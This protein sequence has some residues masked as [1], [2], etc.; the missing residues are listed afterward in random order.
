MREN[1]KQAL[2][3]AGRGLRVFPLLPDMKRP[4]FAGWQA[5]A[6]SDPSAIRTWYEGA[7]ADSGVG[8]ATGQGVFVVDADGA[9]GKASL[10]VLEMSGAD[11]GLVVDTPSGGR[12]AYFTA[13]DGQWVPNSVKS[14]SGYPGID[15]RGDGGFVAAPGSSY[16]GKPY[17]LAT[18]GPLPLAPDWLVAAAVGGRKQRDKAD[19]NPLV[20]LDT[21]PAI[22]RAIEY[23]RDKAPGAVAFAFGNDTTYKVAA[24]VKDF[25]IS[26]E[27]TTTLLA[28]HWNE[29]K[30]E[31]PWDI[32]E[33]MAIVA[34]A[35]A[36]GTSSPGAMSALAEF[37]AV[38]IDEPANDNHSQLKRGL[39]L[40]DFPDAVGKA[41][42][43]PAPHLVDGILEQN[44][45][46]V[47]Y[48]P[49]N[50][51]KTFLC[52]ALAY[53]I[54]AG[55]PWDGHEVDPGAVVYVAAEGG[56]GVNKRL[57]ALNTHFAPSSP[58]P[59]A[60]VPCPIDLNKSD[61]DVKA[62]IRLAKGYAASKAQP[63]R[64]IVIDTLSR[65]LAGGDENSSVDMGNFI[66][67][68]DRLRSAADCTV[69]VVHHT[70]KNVANGA[71]G[72]SGLRAAIDTEIEVEEGNLIS[73][74]KQRD[75]DKIQPKNFK[76]EIVTIGTTPNG[77]DITSCVLQIITSAEA[78]FNGRMDVP[79]AAQEYLDILEG[80]AEGGNAVSAK[81]WDAE[82]ATYLTE[83][84]RPLV[85]DRTLKR[86]R[87]TLLE[88]SRVAKV[89]RTDFI[90][91]DA[92]GAAGP[93]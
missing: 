81:D 89:G 5:A 29:T 54:A 88:S 53:H 49:S 11:I 48:G 39:Y 28:E 46:A 35:Y 71:R 21:E 1:I 13:P 91:L 60:L 79:P 82:F 16:N 2:H 47:V 8:V 90:M 66:K 26:E 17:T 7:Y 75:L 38:S 44:T 86:Y 40:V 58:P 10:D 37:D 69:L 19:S 77:K 56:R 61:A 41:L 20:E 62:I 12:H 30:A 24:K 22:A 33:I 43:D 14:L 80:L 73:V 15:I 3:L 42:A 63:L 93:S 18:D 85:Q 23:L 55:L 72:W 27:M 34:N 6:T 59:L 64:L 52:T 9:Q 67:N 51:G 68:I 84:G 92:D 45:F 25:G 65:A 87:K 74:E 83:G 32:E 76:L 4:A 50:S 57:A 78:E 36:H 31:P 70:G